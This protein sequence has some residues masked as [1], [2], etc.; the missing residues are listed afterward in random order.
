MKKDVK[1]SVQIQGDQVVKTFIVGNRRRRRFRRE[2]LALE[3]L[4]GIDGI[5]QLLAFDENSL[6]LTM[7]RIPG[8]SFEQAKSVD[9]DFFIRLGEL[10]EAMLKRGVARH[11]MPPRDVIV[12]PDG[13]PGLVDYERITLR[14]MRYSP[15]WALSCMISRFHLLRLIGK[16]RPD[17]LTPAQKRKL[18]WQLKGQRLFRRWIE[19]R[20]AHFVEPER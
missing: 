4:Q 13:T 19:W 10:V 9:D 1:N 7:E 8:C 14:Y 12:R 20:R 3:R 18:G 6:N 5:P 15:V 11:S 17:L 16:H 2:R